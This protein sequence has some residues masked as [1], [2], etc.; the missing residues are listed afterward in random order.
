MVTR[1]RNL[2][3]ADPYFDSVSLLAPLSGEDGDTTS[4]DLSNNAHTITFNGNSVLDGDIRKFGFT[5]VKFD[6]TEDGLTIADDASLTLGSGDFT[7]ECHVRFNGTQTA[8]GNLDTHK[9]VWMSKWT[10]GTGTAEW[11]WGWRF[12]G[13]IYWTYSVNGTNSVDL[14]VQTSYSPPA[15]QWIHFAVCRSG[16]TVYHYIDGVMS[17]SGS[18]G[19]DTIYDSATEVRISGY[20]N[21]GTLREEFDGWVENVRITKGVCRYPD[22]TTFTP[23][24]RAY[25]TVQNVNGDQYF[26]NVVLLLP[27]D[28]TD[29]ATTTTDFSNSAHTMTF[30]GTAQLDTAVVKYGDSSLLLDGDSD[31]ITAPDSTDWQF[32]S[33]DFTIEFWYYFNN[34]IDDVFVSYWSNT[35]NERCWYFG[36]VDSVNQWRWVHYNTSNQQNVAMSYSHNP[37]LSQWYH[38]AITRASGTFRF[39]LDGTL[40]DTDSTWSA[41]VIRTPGT[42][43]TLGVGNLF[44]NSNFY[45]DG[46]FDDLR[47]T[48]GVA[49]YTSSFTPPTGPYPTS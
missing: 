44:S 6:G 23:P 15:D 27:F 38:I 30:E 20:G 8:T 48:K 19:T 29:G 36:W 46:Q 2:P 43:T 24:E 40:V 4:T 10:N 25:P 13:N 22:G 14:N 32:G 26:N 33:G 35:T 3:Q 31:Y 5:S 42:T 9:G 37:S 39:F 16:T 12:D 11:V 47:I 17:G 34:I 41:D 18:M 45:S 49:R 21:A 1:P 7:M 28:G